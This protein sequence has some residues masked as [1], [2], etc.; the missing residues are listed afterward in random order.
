[1]AAGPP[2]TQLALAD[3]EMRRLNGAALHAEL[4]FPD[5]VS[6]LVLRSLATR[7]RAKDT[8]VADLGWLPS[9]P[10]RA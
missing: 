3:L 7:V 1:M 6:A 4:P 9:P 5:E 10:G 8:D 2:L